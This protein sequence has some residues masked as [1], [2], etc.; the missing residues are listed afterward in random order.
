[1]KKGGVL[2]AKGHDPL[3]E[4]TSIRTMVSSRSEKGVPPPSVEKSGSR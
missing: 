1:M 2:L 4:D 3:D